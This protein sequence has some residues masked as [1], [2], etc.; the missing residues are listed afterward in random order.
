MNKSILYLSLTLLLLTSCVSKKK[1]LYFQDSDKYASVNISQLETKIQVNDILSITIS[2]FVPETAVPYNLQNYSGT[3][4]IESLKLNGYLVNSKGQIEMPILGTVTVKNKTIIQLK[5]E[6]KDLLEQGEHIVQ[7]SVTIRILNGKVT[8]LGEVNNPG[9]YAFTEQ[10]ISLPQA[11]G[12]AGDLTINGKRNDILLIREID[13]VREISHINLTTAN[14]MND[15]KYSIKQNDVIIVN[16]NS[17]KIQSGGYN[18][19]DLSAILGITSLIVSLL[20]L[21]KK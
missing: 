18:I 9:T 21:L 8:I 4:N 20:I 5:K 10:Y 19:G 14:W 16:P 15:P 12:Y 6:I 1:I 7:P 2:S 13:G 3:T 17:K 11:L